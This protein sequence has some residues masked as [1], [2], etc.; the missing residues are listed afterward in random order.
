MRLVPPAAYTFLER[1]GFRASSSGVG[2][3]VHLL[4]LHGAVGAWDEVLCLMVP[5]TA[6]MGVALAVLKRHPDRAD[7]DEATAVADD[8]HAPDEPS[9]GAADTGR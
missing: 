5:A 7:D 1:L 8:A 9:A 2:H 3:I 4:P 6:I